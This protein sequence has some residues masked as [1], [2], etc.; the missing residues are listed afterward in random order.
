VRVL[1]TGAAGIIGTAV[2]N[3]L[4]ASG[5]GVVEIEAYIPEAHGVPTW[6]RD[7]LWPSCA[8]S[9]AHR[10]SVR[11]GNIN[12]GCRFLVRQSP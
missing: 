12:G 5:H 7:S 2:G 9:G 3:A 11:V 8:A 6:G 1:L 4:R 10:G